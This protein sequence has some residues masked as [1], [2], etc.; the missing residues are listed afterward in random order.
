MNPVRTSSLHG[1]VQGPHQHQHDFSHTAQYPPE[2]E[3][4]KTDTDP[5]ETNETNETNEATDND[6]SLPTF[7]V[8]AEYPFESIDSSAL[9]FKEGDVIEVLTRLESGWWDGLAGD[10]RGWFPSNYVRLISDEEAEEWFLQREVM[11][12]GGIQE[13]AGREEGEEEEE[14]GG[15]AM[16]SLDREEDE[17]AVNQYG[18]AT[19]IAKRLAETAKEDQDEH[20]DHLDLDLDL[21]LDLDLG[22]LGLDS[23]AKQLMASN[24]DTDHN[25][26]TED[27]R[28]Q[29]LFY[30]PKQSYS[31]RPHRDEIDEGH[32]DVFYKSQ[33]SY[34]FHRND[35]DTLI[36]TISPAQHSVVSSSAEDHLKSSSSPAP[37]QTPETGVIVGDPS[38]FWIP[39]LND[40]G[41]IYYH[42]TQ[43]GEDAWEL[44][45]MEGPEIPI[46]PLTDAA[47]LTSSGRLRKRSLQRKSIDP[48]YPLPRRTSSISSVERLQGFGSYTQARLMPNQSRLKDDGSGYILSDIQSGGHREALEAFSFER[49]PIKGGETN[50]PRSSSAR[51]ISQTIFGSLGHR[52]SISQNTKSMRT[53]L[54]NAISV[55]KATLARINAELI[56]PPVDDATRLKLMLD[57][58]DD[59][60]TIVITSAE[61]Y[62]AACA[63][64]SASGAIDPHY[65]DLPEAQKLNE[66]VGQLI[67]E[68]RVLITTSRHAVIGLC[69]LLGESNAVGPYATNERIHPAQRRVLAALSK[70]VFFC[71]SA[72]G[73]SW[74]LP[75]TVERLASDTLDLLGAIK[76]FVRELY[77]FGAL[78]EGGLGLK[79]VQP[80]FGLQFRYTSGTL[81]PNETRKEWTRINEETIK[82]V[83]IRC[84]TIMASR[85]LPPIDTE[86]LNDHFGN[87]L[88]YISDIDAPATLDIDG[89]LRSDGAEIYDKSGKYNQLASQARDYYRQYDD[90]TQRLFDNVAMLLLKNPEEG[91]TAA[92][93]YSALAFAGMEEIQN[94]LAT[95]FA[96]G[97]E[98]NNALV[99][100]SWRGRIGKRSIRIAERELNYRHIRSGSHSSSL[101]S[102]RVSRTP[103]R[104][105]SISENAQESLGDVRGARPSKRPSLT[106]SMTSFDQLNPL[107]GRRR[108]TATNVSRV[109]AS[110]SMTSLSA[111]LEQEGTTAN[112]FRNSTSNL[113]RGLSFMRNRSGSDVDDSESAI[114]VRCRGLAE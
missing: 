88:K 23:L 87:L 73:M 92:S 53:T 44:P 11:L 50:I 95:L 40:D 52:A 22:E 2:N 18:P 47:S 37:T 14:Y 58:I 6:E 113:I 101:T 77:R 24:D 43:T 25:R 49:K 69:S 54:S 59:Q 67:P 31:S 89:V 20:D 72:V 99:E 41:Q 33:P 17:D 4:N 27:D 1:Q 32:Q 15:V 36:P 82:E 106:R 10:R 105:A 98:Q 83:K 51:R 34:S 97:S 29:D 111:A 3:D 76:V 103:S 78:S 65:T 75:G 63:S 86:S 38:D 5:H 79:P 26:E 94:I 100:L 57:S 108:S 61:N 45:N 16:G 110:S 112:S 91:D 21:N 46:T 19:W 96:I 8:Q 12:A 81:T 80:A 64:T 9:S 93:E 70:V 56:P 55:E 68:I 7:F 60:V 71:H 74:P 13:G 84:E 62:I 35:L 109:S 85:D 90:I 104:S 107:S 114:Y 39:S 42:N 30:K 28:H 66:A 48:L 102:T